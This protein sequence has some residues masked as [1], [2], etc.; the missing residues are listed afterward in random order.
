MSLSY[1]IDHVVATLEDVSIEVAAKS[2]LTHISTKVDDKSGDVIA[3]YV[4]ASGDARFP[5]NVIYRV[6]A[7]SRA[8]SPTRRIQVSFNTWASE[9]DSVT[10]I[11][12]RKPISG[13]FSLTVPAD[14]TLEIADVMQLAG[15]TFS[16]LY[17]SVTTKV[18]STSY[19]SQ[20]LYGAPKVA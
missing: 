4:L 6:S 5:A 2:E 20:L 1:T 9:T 19:L 3:T 15:N 8:G 16:F 14:L 17:P 13:S 18:R 10:G 11:V 12:V 7:Q